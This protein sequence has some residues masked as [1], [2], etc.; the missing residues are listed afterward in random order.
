MRSEATK[1]GGEV[2]PDIL[3][4]RIIGKSKMRSTG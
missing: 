4:K 3:C 2:Y 1:L